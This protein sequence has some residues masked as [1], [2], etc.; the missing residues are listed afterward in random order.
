V[1]DNLD[2]ALEHAKPGTEFESFRQGVAMTRKLFEDSLAKHG[3][4]GF[5]SRGQPFDP[6]RHEAMQQVETD[7]MP[8]N[9]VHTE[10]LRGFTLH[11]RLVRPA[12]VMVS[13]AREAPAKAAPADTSSP[14]A[15]G[16]GGDN[17]NS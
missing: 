2:R 15:D 14:A 13:K 6:H 17:N 10:L 1:L 16:P 12:L 11:D 7:E 9:H 4:K 5:S 3:V 8:P